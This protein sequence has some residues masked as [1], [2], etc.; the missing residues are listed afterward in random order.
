MKDFRVG[1]HYSETGHITIKAN[2]VQE[3]EKKVEKIL[4]EDGIDNIKI[5]C[6]NREYGVTDVKS[7]D[8]PL[9]QE[10]EEKLPWSGD[11]KNIEFKKK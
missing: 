4:K 10:A 5:K 9:I 8:G 11:F 6:T 3:A 2:T 1:V 7:L